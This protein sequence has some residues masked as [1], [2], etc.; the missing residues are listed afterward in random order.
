MATNDQSDTIPM[1][2]RP[3]DYYTSNAWTGKIEALEERLRLTQYELERTKALN[4]DLIVGK[5]MLRRQVA[6]LRNRLGRAASQPSKRG[7][8]KL[9]TRTLRGK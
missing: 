7:S 5:G 4:R 2:F 3:E 1:G 9:G 6:S 8:Y